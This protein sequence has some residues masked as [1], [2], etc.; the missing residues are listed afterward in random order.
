MFRLKYKWY[1]NTSKLWMVFIWYFVNWLAYSS[2]TFEKWPPYLHRA[3]TLTFVVAYL[4]ICSHRFALCKI[5]AIGK[6][7]VYHVRYEKHQST[8]V[9]ITAHDWILI[10]E[11][12]D[13]KIMLIAQV[14]SRDFMHEPVI[15]PKLGLGSPHFCCPS[16]FYARLLHSFSN[17]ISATASFLIS[18][19]AIFLMYSV[20]LSFLLVL[21]CLSVALSDGRLRCYG[22]L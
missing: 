17:P 13:E 5:S 10:M 16:F 19:K 20:C 4:Y 12:E 14:L 1:S 7:N 6:S 11:A 8:Y 3:W 15:K 9:F 18:V 2:E 21:L 22:D